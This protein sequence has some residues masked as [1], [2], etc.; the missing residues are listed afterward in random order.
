MSD[1]VRNN[2]PISTNAPAEKNKSAPASSG[3]SKPYALS[4]IARNNPREPIQRLLLDLR[5][6]ASAVGNSSSNPSANNSRAGRLP[7]RRNPHQIV[8]SATQTPTFHPVIRLVEF[9]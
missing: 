1:A 4:A 3:L 7:S 8:I 6:A 2:P 5:S 9:P